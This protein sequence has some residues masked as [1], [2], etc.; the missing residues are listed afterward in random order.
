MAVK[1]SR[2]GLI[3][4][5]NKDLTRVTSLITP[6]RLKEEYLFGISLID[7]NT[8]LELTDKNLQSFIDNAV[9]LF[10]HYLDLAITP[11]QDFI[12]YRDYHMNEYLDW[13][14]FSLN[15]Y[16][17]IQIKEMAMVYLRNDDGTPLTKTTIPEAWIRLQPHDGIVRMF[18]NR[19]I[20]LNLQV[21]A[22]GAYFPELL[23]SGMVPH[24]WEIK[25]DYGFCPGGI[26]VLLNQ[27]IGYAAAMQTLIIMGNLVLGAGIAS[28]SI[29]LDGL[30][31][32]INTTQSAENSAYSATI[33]DY[34]SRLFGTREGDP[35]AIITILKNY[36]KG[37]DINLI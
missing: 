37:Q 33:K 24:L 35:F 14:Y 13:G 12:E 9:S 23:R 4:S 19:N 22:A 17:I 15:N 34:S 6:K 29:S 2:D 21:N 18:P 20:P 16:P 11:V 7:P 5:G 8:G 1:G 27:A 31:Q 10:E 36:Y 30:S 28:S 26:P 25:Y 3:P 32:S